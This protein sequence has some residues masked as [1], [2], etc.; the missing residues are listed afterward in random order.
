MALRIKYKH[1]GKVLKTVTVCM[2][3]I[4]GVIENHMTVTTYKSTGTKESC[5]HI[6]Q[7]ALT[8][9]HVETVMLTMK[10]SD[11]S[12][13]SPR[14]FLESGAVGTIACPTCNSSNCDF[15]LLVFAT[16][17]LITVVTKLKM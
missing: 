16:S 17:L 9:I 7:K 15:L 1:I 10:G 5:D 3:G 8:Q 14:Q 2:K 6:H 13:L 4:C 12:H 11:S